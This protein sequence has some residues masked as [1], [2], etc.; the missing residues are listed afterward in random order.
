MTLVK[1][2]GKKALKALES[3]KKKLGA[4]DDRD[5]EEKLRKLLGCLASPPFRF[6]VELG[7]EEST[8][9][10]NR[11]EDAGLDPELQDFMKK[12]DEYAQK[13]PIRKPQ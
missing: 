3:L 4:R 7:K 9:L 6:E 13:H 12:A 2:K 1:N 11:M 10:L 8:A 5:A